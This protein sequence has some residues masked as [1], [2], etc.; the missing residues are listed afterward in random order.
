MLHS[1]RRGFTLI[2]LLVV[3]AIIGVLIA[4]LLP[5]VQQARE[6][7]RRVQCTNNLKQ[8]ALAVLNYES[9]FKSLPPGSKSCCWGTWQMWVLPYLEQDTMYNGFNFTGGGLGEYDV[10]RL[11]RYEG[12]TNTTVTQT[13]MSALTCPSSPLNSP[14][15]SEPLKLSG[16]GPHLTAH[17]YA[18]NYGNTT[19]TQNDLFVGTPQQVLFGGSPWADLYGS[20]VGEQPGVTLGRIIDGTS[21]TFMFGEVV[22]TV[23]SWPSASANP[24]GDIR[25][26]TWWR[27]ASG[28]ETYIGPNS[29]LPDIIY[30]SSWCR[31]LLDGNPPCTG[32]QSAFPNG[33]YGSRSKHPGGVNVAFCDGSATFIGDSISIAVWRALSTTRGREVVSGDSY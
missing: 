13:R 15:A 6:G 10:N 33:M 3:I 22:Q 28:F 30:T 2:E 16:N 8:L 24:L 23:G 14:W 20:T 18:A 29:G 11:F 19:L 27:D 26:F 31:S 32:P 25:G 5:A 1:K 12:A 21:K 17:N 4:L 9:A 7:A